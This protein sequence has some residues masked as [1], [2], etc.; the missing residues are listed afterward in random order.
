VP[1]SWF[2]NGFFSGPFTV[3]NQPFPD[4]G[5]AW[6]SGS[7]GTIAAT[8]ARVR[9]N[10]ERIIDVGGDILRS[11]CNAGGGKLN[12]SGAWPIVGLG[13]KP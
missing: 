9:P 10:D 4:G 11:R 2:Q 5:W 1:R 13:L 8:L 12:L 7:G 3:F 6:I